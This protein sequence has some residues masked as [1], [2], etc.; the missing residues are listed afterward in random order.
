MSVISYYKLGRMSEDSEIDFDGNDL[1]SS[2]EKSCLVLIEK[3][4]DSFL[5]SP[6]GYFLHVEVENIGNIS[7]IKSHKT[8]KYLC[9]PPLESDRLKKCLIDRDRK[10]SWEA[11]NLIPSVNC[12]DN[13]DPLIFFDFIKRESSIVEFFKSGKYKLFDKKTLNYMLLCL[14]DIEVNF[15][16]DYLYENLDLNL[17]K[18]WSSG[19]FVLSKSLDDF[20]GG[21]VKYI[22]VEYDFIADYYRKGDYKKN[23]WCHI[24]Y[25]IRKKT[26]PNKKVCVLATAK[27]EGVYLLDWVSHYKSLGVEDIFIYTNGNEDGSDILL[28]SLAEKNIINVVFSDVDHGVSAQEKAY[29]HALSINS[30]ILD[31]EWCIVVDLDE[32]LTINRSN[33]NSLHDYLDWQEKLGDVHSIG[34]NWVYSNGSKDSFEWFDKRLTKRI[35]NFSFEPHQCVKSIIKPHFFVSSHCHTPRAFFDDQSYLSKNDDG[36]PRDWSLSGK[37]AISNYPSVNYLCVLHFFFKTPEEFIWKYSRNRGDLPNA[38]GIFIPEHAALRDMRFF[39]Q[40]IENVSENNKTSFEYYLESSDCVYDLLLSDA[41]I[42][43]S[44]CKVK[45]L[46]KIR[47]DAAVEAFKV[48]VEKN[49]IRNAYF[50]SIIGYK[51]RGIAYSIEGSVIK[52]NWDGFDYCFFVKNLKDYIQMHHFKGEL[53]EVQ[54]LEII[55]K[56]IHSGAIVYDVGSNVG[57]HA[58]FFSKSLKAKKV[59]VFEANPVAID[60]LKINIF[61]ND[62][63]S[64]V[65]TSYL[66][67]GIGK[68]NSLMT[69]YQSDENNLGGNRLISIA[70]NSSFDSRINIPVVSL[71]FLSIKDPP[72]FVKID[73][74]GMEM[75][76]LDGMAGL[77]NRYR[78]SIFIE[79]DNSNSKDFFS[80]IC[81]NKYR[82][83]CEYKRYP[84]NTNYYIEYDC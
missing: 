25:F 69:I 75:K 84:T 1:Y 67:F 35:N 64:L 19:D 38:K 71:D 21:N 63:S 73:V 50:N 16:V 54:E 26:I 27:N 62:L 42:Y 28:S 36:T 8:K 11:F 3:E 24:N 37:P 30:D 44:F 78:P 49:N 51:G 79:V 74:E 2:K 46:T 45:Y 4:G 15:F 13:F 60:L 17:I 40:S 23:F 66:G 5:Y 61:L 39:T 77:I 55:K 47:F 32:F 65:D 80:W 41:E 33:F 52:F 10:G 18:D 81:F 14:S 12:V 6:A 59:Y 22:G 7:Y 57:N 56:N 76:V 72:D 34:V 82:I 58:V 20:F 29:A 43:E 68:E 9:A 48:F 53:Y 83:V 70:G 31:F